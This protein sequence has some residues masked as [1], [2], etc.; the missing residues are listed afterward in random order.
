MS[1]HTEAYRVIWEYDDDPDL[2]WLEQWNT[3]ETYKGNEVQ[4]GCH[5]IPMPFDEYMATYGN[6]ERHV[7]LVCRVERR[8]ETCGAWETIEAVCGFDFMDWQGYS[9]GE[10]IPED[11]HMLANSYQI[12]ESNNLLA[13]A[14]RTA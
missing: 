10:Y 3:P 12:E 6:P 2:S 11:I 4:E 9:L 7:T 14:Q 5:G 8:C 1:K 13:D